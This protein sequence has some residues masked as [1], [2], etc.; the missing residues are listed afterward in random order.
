M[1]MNKI[2]WYNFKLSLIHTWWI[3]ISDAQVNTG[4]PC[5]ETELIR[6]TFLFTLVE[7]LILINKIR[8]KLSDALKNL[9]LTLILHTSFS[10]LSTVWNS[11]RLTIRDIYTNTSKQTAFLIRKDAYSYTCVILMFFARKNFHFSFH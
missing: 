1:D 11:D 7:I 6:H 2:E 9:A 5:T 10:T 8:S 4:V 3:K